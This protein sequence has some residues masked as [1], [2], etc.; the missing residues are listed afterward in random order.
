MGCSSSR[1]TV[2]EPVRSSEL[3]GGEDDTVSKQ[4]CRGDSAVSKLTTDSGVVLDTGEVPTLLG[5]VPRKLSPLAAHIPGL[6]QESGERPK[7]SDIL[8]QLRGQGIIAQPRERASGEAYNIMIDDR[9]TP[10][11]RPPPHLESLK[12]KRDQSV[13]S[14]V[15]MEERMRQAEEERKELN[16]NLRPKSAGVHDPEAASTSG[17]GNVVSPVE[18]LHTPDAPE[19][20]PSPRGIQQEPLDPDPTQTHG[21]GDGGSGG[22]REGGGEGVRSGLSGQ[23]LS[24]SLEMENDSTFQQT[25]QAEE[26]F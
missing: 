3:D 1:F 20:P 4:G 12:G 9:E 8:E 15:D 21:G 18:I 11:R 23:L 17:E 5:A 16:V 6:A 22:V 26:Q 19:T 25:E 2:V 10:K 13:T 14:Q 24:A 7:S